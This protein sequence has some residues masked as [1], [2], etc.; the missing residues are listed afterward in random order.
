MFGLE[1]PHK[2]LGILTVFLPLVT[3]LESIVLVVY[4]S[5]FLIALPL[6][7]IFLV[8]GI[9]SLSCLS[10]FL[11]RKWLL[12]ICGIVIL[13]LLCS[14][15]HLVMGKFACLLVNWVGREWTGSL[16]RFFW[17]KHK[18]FCWLY[19]PFKLFLSLTGLI[20]LCL[21]LISWFFRWKLQRYV[22]SETVETDM[23]VLTTMNEQPS[24]EE[25]NAALSIHSDLEMMSYFI[26]FR[27]IIAIVVL[28]N[29]LCILS[30]VYIPLRNIWI[31]TRQ[32]T[33]LED[34]HFILTPG[35]CMLPFP[36][37]NILSESSPFLR[38]NQ[39]KGLP[40]FR[41]R[42]EWDAEWLSLDDMDGF[43]R[44]SPIVFSLE[45]LNPDDLIDY[46]QLYL[47]L[48]DN[49]T[50]ILI[51]ATTGDRV[52]HFYSSNHFFDDSD[53]YAAVAMHP[54]EP[55][56]E[57][58]R[59]I[60]GVRNIRNRRNH[61]ILAPTPKGFQIIRDNLTCATFDETLCRHHQYVQLQQIYHRNIFPV[62]LQYGFVLPQI[63]IAWQF[64]VKS[65]NATLQFANT[66][67]SILYT[68]WLSADNQ[69]DKPRIEIDEIR[70]Y[71]CKHSLKERG[72]VRK[73]HGQVFN[74]PLFLE[75]DTP[76]S[77][78]S[79]PLRQTGTSVVPFTVLLPCSLCQ[80]GNQASMLLQYGHG[81]MG[82]Q[83]EA[84]SDYLKR[85]ANDYNAVIWAVDWR[86]MSQYDIL[87][88]FKM[89][90]FEPDHFALL[91]HN[92][93][94][95]LS[96]ATVVLWTMLSGNFLEW[97]A[98]Q[99]NSTPVFPY[100]SMNGYHLNLSSIPIGYYG[101]SQG[102]ILGAAL[103]GFSPMY[104]SGVLGVAGAP[105][106]L[107]LSQSID[108]IPYIRALQVELYLRD[109][110]LYLSLI[111]QLWDIGEPTGWLSTLIDD[112]KYILIHA[113]IQDKQ[114]PIAGAEVLGRGLQTQL[115]GPRERTVLGW[116][117]DEN[118]ITWLYPH[119]QLVEWS[120]AQDAGFPPHECIRRTWK[121]V[122]QSME[123]LFSQGYTFVQVCQ[124]E[125]D[126]ELSSCTYV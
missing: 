111:Q 6:F 17:W 40:I 27:R 122:V 98:M 3:F 35:N 59:Y 110:P 99:V 37:D 125:N 7:L 100:C 19:Y 55:L 4:S 116:S 34:C 76:G 47:S 22:S 80:T 85:M 14:T 57:G 58:H 50:T 114:V 84:Q 25:Q 20:G 74:V 5:S 29:V 83:G 120:V 64:T 123:F 117:N 24:M 106:S 43:S 97:E 95:G 68:L 65:K 78:L 39:F 81:L 61:S 90:L 2:P 56:Q 15:V 8:L 86:G 115:M 108:A 79:H 26:L 109:V 46:D 62:L 51:D 88:V 103:V 67:R 60:V 92:I 72:W 105:Y 89:L 70:E 53:P 102:G 21:I 11:Y 101:N 12:G 31:Q 49:S 94:Q 23:E 69:A 44:L 32:T 33:N 73:I 54:A 41:F 45:N 30:T 38:R 18:V 10:C 87:S 77:K 82:S 9:L 119:S 16:H 36:S 13:F 42:K 1:K 48:S 118:N 71:D 104:S 107:L 93:L 121:Q 91:P 113:A 75:K 126:C 124:E 112:G 28:L 63:Q 96:D 66:I 52:A